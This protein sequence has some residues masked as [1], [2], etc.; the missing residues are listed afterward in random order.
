MLPEVRVVALHAVFVEI[1]WHPYWFKATAKD[2]PKPKGE[3]A[4]TGKKVNKS[5]YVRAIF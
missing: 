1:I 2:F 5:D 4:S 3:T